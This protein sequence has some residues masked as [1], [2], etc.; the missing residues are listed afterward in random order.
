MELTYVFCCV[1][2]YM[3]GKITNGLDCRWYRYSDPDKRAT[4]RAKLQTMT[5]F[6]RTQA[7]TKLRKKREEVSQPNS[8]NQSNYR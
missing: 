5:A 4:M 7:I 2:I 1:Y 3:M 8:T 6:E